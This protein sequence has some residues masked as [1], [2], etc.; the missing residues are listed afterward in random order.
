[1]N[2][3]IYFFINYERKPFSYGTNG[4]I[5]FKF[6]YLSI[7]VHIPF[8]FLPFYDS[9]TR[10]FITIIQTGILQRSATKLTTGFR[11]QAMI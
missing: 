2:P 10:V 8:Y 3:I 4:R 5:Y 6:I 1:M 7:Y 9:E 11:L